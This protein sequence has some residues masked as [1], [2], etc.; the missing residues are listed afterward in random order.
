[1]GETSWV[2]IWAAI[3]FSVGYWTGSKKLKNS[4]AEEVNK[5]VVER[6]NEL[7]NSDKNFGD[8]IDGFIKKY[9]WILEIRHN[10]EK[11]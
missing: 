6:I 11:Q 3:A 5:K 4:M 2:F 9:R 8:K 7:S 10:T 1:M